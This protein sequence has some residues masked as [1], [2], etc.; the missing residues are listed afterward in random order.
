MTQRKKAQALRDL[1]NADKLLVLPNIWDPIGARV[2]AHQGYPAVATASAAISASLGF[3]DGEVIGRDAMLAA[4]ARICRVIDVPVTAD[5]E[6]G[7]GATLAEVAESTE[8]LIATGAVGLNIEDSL[9]EGHS[10]RPVADQCE[11]I[12]QV[13]ATASALGVDLV[14]NARVDTFLCDQ[15][16]DTEARLTET[17]TRARAYLEAGA[18]CIYPIG[19]GDRPTLTTLRAEIVAPL[20]ALAKPDAVSLAEMTAIGINRVSFGP[21]IFRSCL[22]RFARITDD[23]SRGQDYAYF[24]EEMLSQIETAKFL[25]KQGEKRTG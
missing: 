15:F 21:F 23:L 24:G 7:Y 9:G 14:I 12:A 2:L 6:T 1:H 11:R 19:P 18:D 17:V 22:H 10:L 16:G 8:R 13:R 3:V 20:N 25:C 4:V 5:M